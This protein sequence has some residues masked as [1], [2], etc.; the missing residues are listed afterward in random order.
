MLSLQVVGCVVRSRGQVLVLQPV[1][2]EFDIVVEGGAGVGW[3]Q[4]PPSR[5]FALGVRVY[6]QYHEDNLW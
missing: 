4:R 1:E 6:A 5:L 3:M 2:P